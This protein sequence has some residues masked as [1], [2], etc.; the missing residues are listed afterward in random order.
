MQFCVL[1][2][3]TDVIWVALRGQFCMKLLVWIKK[4]CL[5][6]VTHVILCEFDI[7]LFVWL[8]ADIWGWEKFLCL[9]Y[10]NTLF[11]SHFCCFLQQNYGLGLGFRFGLSVDPVLYHLALQRLSLKTQSK[12][13]F[14]GPFSS[15]RNVP[16]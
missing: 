15:R 6:W 14:L 11:F 8:C 10:Y 12:I 16:V 13:E 2:T 4:N 3:V 7:I 1:K 5:F 9:V